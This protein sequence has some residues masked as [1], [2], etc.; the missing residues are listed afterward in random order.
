M[1]LHVCDDPANGRLD[2]EHVHV[3]QGVRVVVPLALLARRV[4]E[5]EQHRRFDAEPLARQAE[6]PDT[7]RAQVFDRAN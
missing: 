5:A 6:L 3:G 7:Q 4:V 1:R 2:V